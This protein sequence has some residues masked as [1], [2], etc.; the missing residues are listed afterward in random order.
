MLKL[1]YFLGVGEVKLNQCGGS[2][3]IE[4]AT[5]EQSNLAY[6][7][8]YW[9]LFFDYFNQS[10]TILIKEGVDIDNEALNLKI[11]EV[12][13]YDLALNPESLPAENESFNGD[14]TDLEYSSHTE[15][16]ANIK[17]LEGPQKGREVCKKPQGN[18]EL[19]EMA[20]NNH[21]NLGKSQR[22]H[23]A[24]DRTV[25][26]GLERHR[27]KYKSSKSSLGEP[28]SASHQGKNEF[29]DKSEVSNM[30]YDK[31]REGSKSYQDRMSQKQISSDEPQHKVAVSHVQKGE[32]CDRPQKNHMSN[33]RPQDP[34][35]VTQSNLCLSEAGHE[36][37][38]VSDIKQ[39][40]SDQGETT[41]RPRDGRE[42]RKKP[43]IHIEAIDRHQV[44][45]SLPIRA[46]GVT[47]PRK[48]KWLTKGGS[49]ERV[50]KRKKTKMA[51]QLT[52][53]FKRQKKSTS[54]ENISS[55]DSITG[56]VVDPE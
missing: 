45:S 32:I 54:E 20:W 27:Q 12:Q 22:K 47:S 14:K 38:V 36:L 21:N 37:Q 50:A 29:C 43:Q 6:S 31:N 53:N 42:L 8:S 17:R 55:Y 40:A 30:F 52:D 3:T 15:K 10:L 39:K 25:I 56:S 33:E 23:E 28:T 2:G 7:I 35:G 11:M 34:D 19:S 48:E 41:E 16:C 44:K 49:S 4:F 13:T 46:I 51:D 24:S 26:Q 1:Q 18:A 9:R 5:L